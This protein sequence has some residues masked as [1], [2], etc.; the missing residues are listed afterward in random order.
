MWHKRVHPLDPLTILCSTKFKFIRA[1]IYHNAFISIKLIIRHKFI[2]YYINYSKIFIIH[3]DSR[4][5]QHI[6]VI[7]KNRKPTAFYSQNF[8][9]CTKKL[10]EF[11][12]KIVN[13]IGNSKGA[14]CSYY[15]KSCNSIY[16]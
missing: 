15:R 7:I 6:G 11:I 1:D 10:Y 12:T 9:P 8:N 13:Y 4:K 3:L 14:M 2:F 16:G 5:M